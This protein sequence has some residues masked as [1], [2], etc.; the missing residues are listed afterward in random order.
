MHNNEPLEKDHFIQLA[1]GSLF[2]RETEPQDE[3]T[4]MVKATNSA[5]MAEAHVRVTVICPLAPECEWVG[6]CG[7]VLEPCG[8][9]WCRCESACV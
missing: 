2:I 5:G 7:L 8:L 3:G 4:Y 9:L 1:D 6:G